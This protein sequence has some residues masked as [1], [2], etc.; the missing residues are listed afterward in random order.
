MEV[1]DNIYQHC[2]NHE[3]TIG[4]YL[5]L[6]LILLI[7]QFFFK[8]WRKLSQFIWFGPSYYTASVSRLPLSVG[9]TTVSPVDAVLNLGK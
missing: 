7:I 3:I 6:H 1:L 2:D 9:G 5:D 8:N 4:I